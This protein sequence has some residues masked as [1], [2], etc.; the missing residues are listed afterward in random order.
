MNK[1]FYLI[2]VCGIYLS[3]VSSKVSNNCSVLSNAI[4][5]TIKQD[6]FNKYR[7][8]E[9]LSIVIKNRDKLLEIQNCSRIKNIILDTIQKTPRYIKLEEYR[10]VGD[11]VR[12]QISCYNEIEEPYNILYST[13]YIV[14]KDKTLILNEKSSPYIDTLQIKKQ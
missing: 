7:E 13:S 12:L 9:K 14:Q 10:Y 4:D 5:M 8:R 3:C 6:F 1:I 2:C 11:L